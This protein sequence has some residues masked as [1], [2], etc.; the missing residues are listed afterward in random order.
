MLALVPI[1]GPI[2]AVVLFGFSGITLAFPIATHP[3]ISTIVL[4]LIF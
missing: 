4:A 3:L 1:I 2:L